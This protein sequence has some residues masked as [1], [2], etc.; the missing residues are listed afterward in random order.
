MEVTMHHRERSVAGMKLV[1]RAIVTL[2]VASTAAPAR[3][4]ITPDARRV[5]DRFLEASGGAGTFRAI[6]TLRIAARI[7]ALGFQG[8]TTTYA[9]RPDRRASR[10]QLG[11]FQIP[12]GFD[13][14]SGWRI[15]PSGKLL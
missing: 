9:E 7:E 11:P 6:K 12:E 15:D 4:T 13:G 8:T 14:T 2:L 10:T 1:L 3:A 5:V